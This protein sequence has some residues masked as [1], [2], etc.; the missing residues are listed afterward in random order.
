MPV[1]DI[2]RPL[3]PA[4]EPWP[5]DTPLSLAWGMRL[6]DGASCNVSAITLSPHVGTHA[7]A[8]YHYSEEGAAMAA[9]A[10]DPYLGPATV[11]DLPG[12]TCITAAD[13]AP[14]L[15]A[16]ARRTVLGTPGP[17][18]RG[19]DAVARGVTGRAPPPRDRAPRDPY[20]FDRGFTCLAPD[21]VAL[22]AERGCR[23]VGTDAPSVDHLTSQDLPA[24]KACLAHNIYILENLE[25]AH[26]PDGEY[27]LIAL[28]LRLEGADGS[29]VRAVLR[30]P[31]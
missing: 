5:G 30:R 19:P 31:D 24:H 4:T 14:L 27:E 3:G 8:P 15:P 25:L 28:P 17:A 20:A 11:I 7:D 9:V 29:P 18:P 6:A 16:A 10:L 21:A 2:S 12:R 23:L 1:Y 26:V 13:L 22:L